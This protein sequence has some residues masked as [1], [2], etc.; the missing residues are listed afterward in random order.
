MSTFGGPPRSPTSA[1]SPA[2]QP[3]SYASA[4]QAPIAP[5]TGESPTPPRTGRERASSRPMSMIGGYQPPLMDTQ[6]TIPELLPIFTFLNSH[7]N[8]LYQEGYFLKLN[9]LDTREWFTHIHSKCP[10]YRIQQMDDR[11]RIGLGQSALL[12]SLAQ[13]SH[14]GTLRLWMLLDR[15]VRLHLRSSTLPMH[16]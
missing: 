3:Q 2:S 13:Y 9:D 16:Q 15:M 11:I 14:Y 10:A 1:Q 8:K 5:P 7:S 4:T 12:N 6:D